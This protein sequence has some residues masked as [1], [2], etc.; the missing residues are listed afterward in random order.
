MKIKRTDMYRI[1]SHSNY[2]S[3]E[4]NIA[5]RLPLGMF[6][7]LARVFRVMLIRVI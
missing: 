4:E 5:V 1:S 2:N 6:V 3:I 7:I